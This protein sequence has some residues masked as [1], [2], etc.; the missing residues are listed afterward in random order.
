M[1]LIVLEVILVVLGVIL[2]VLGGS[3]LHFVSSVFLLRVGGCNTD[4]LGS[5]WGRSKIVL[6]T[7]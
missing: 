2:V 3:R 4:L 5:F 7:F 1:V 6:G